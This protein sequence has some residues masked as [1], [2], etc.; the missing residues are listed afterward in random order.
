[1]DGVPF[2]QWNDELQNYHLEKSAFQIQTLAITARPAR[3]T[4][5]TERRP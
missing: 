5:S 3:A 2:Y 4:A 1:M